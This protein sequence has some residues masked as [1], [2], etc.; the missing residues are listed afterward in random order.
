M[1]N[2][3]NNTDLEFEDTE[4]ADLLGA[5]PQ[6]SAPND[7]EFRVS[8]RIASAR[9]AA[10]PRGLFGALRIAVPAAA[11]LAV[12]ATALFL[13]PYWGTTEPVSTPAEVAVAERPAENPASIPQRETTDIPPTTFASNGPALE[14]AKRMPLNDQLASARSSGPSND[15]PAGTSFVES[16]T[17]GEK[18]YP[19]GINPNVDSQPTSPNAR[20]AGIAIRDVLSQLGISFTP[21]A[22]G[23][24]IN[25]IAANSLAARS[26][27]NA[28]DVI[29]SLNGQRVL[30]DTMLYGAFTARRIV[31]H[32]DGK[33]IELSLGR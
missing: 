16:G 33:T 32:R 31:V 15:D 17:Q 28:G 9:S 13:N 24:R 1:V 11:L 12:T 23:L 8:A 21:T 27:L 26:G 18:I 29:E 3:A 7:F 10:K 14:P 6:V 22:N 30:A 20:Q 25:S 5:L 19:R 4:L 2:R